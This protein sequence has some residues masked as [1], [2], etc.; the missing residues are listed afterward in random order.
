MTGGPPEYYP[1]GHYGMEV[2]KVYHS[3]SVPWQKGFEKSQSKTSWAQSRC[4]S[5]YM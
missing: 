5:I 4:N 3:Q 2:W 1:I